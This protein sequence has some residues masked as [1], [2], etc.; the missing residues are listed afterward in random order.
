MYSFSVNKI[1]R[2]ANIHVI[3]FSVLLFQMCLGSNVTFREYYG[4]R[5]H[6]SETG[7]PEADKLNKMSNIRSQIECFS[8]CMANSECGMTIYSNS[9]KVCILRKIK[10]LPSSTSFIDIPANSIYTML[11]APECPTSAGYTYSPEF[12]L[13]FQISSEKASWNHAADICNEDRG[14]LI[15]MKNIEIMYYIQDKLNQWSDVNFYFGLS[16]DINKNVFVWQNGEVPTFDFWMEDRPD[17]HG[18]NQDCG[19]LDKRS[20]H[21]WNDEL[22]N[23]ATGER[24]ICEIVVR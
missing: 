13:C 16:K 6:P 7:I 20:N 14:Q 15:H 12:R 10:Q 24:Y 8:F 18:G 1:I 17:N 4:T 22:C 2:K 21:S 23:L 9:D 11:Q 3:T 19:L 5:I